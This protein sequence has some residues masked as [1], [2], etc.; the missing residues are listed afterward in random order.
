MATFLV[1]GSASG[2]GQAAAGVAQF[3]HPRDRRRQGRRCGGRP[4]HRHRDAPLP[5]PPWSSSVEACLDGAVLR[6][7]FGAD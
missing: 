7:G 1:T 5:P 4:V 2:M 3:E 6:R